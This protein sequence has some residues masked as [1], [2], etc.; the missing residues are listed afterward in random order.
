MAKEIK[1]AT[2]ADISQMVEI[3]ALNLVKNN[4]DKFDANDFA[5]KGFL[6]GELTESDALEMLADPKNHFVCV[7]KDDEE[8]L[9]YL[10]G[11]DI[12]VSGIEFPKDIS[13][14]KSEKLFY[15]KQIVK[16]PD[17]KNIGQSLVNAMLKEV[18]ERG[19]S[20]VVCRIVYAPFY[21]QNSISFHELFGFRK[22]G[23]MQDKGSNLGIYLKDL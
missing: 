19:Y 14:I 15:Y 22:I 8:V 20:K 4:Q 7:S 17:A 12:S 1:I 6:I 2:V 9:G 10:T 11:C 3:C 16:K 13:E 18:K 21:N 5:K 23:E